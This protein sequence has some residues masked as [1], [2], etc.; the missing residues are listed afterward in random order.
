MFARLV[1]R[2]RAN[3]RRFQVSDNELPASQRWREF[4]AWK[5]ARFFW[6]IRLDVIGNHFEDVAWCDKQWF[7]RRRLG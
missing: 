4:A 5:L 6:M 2:T 3:T 7:G 1:G